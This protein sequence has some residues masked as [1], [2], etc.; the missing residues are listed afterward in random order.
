MQYKYLI[1]FFIFKNVSLF[2]L[3][4]YC[5]NFFDDQLDH[6]HVIHVSFFFFTLYVKLPLKVPPIHTAIIFDSSKCFGNHTINTKI[7]RNS[8]SSIRIDVLGYFI[9]FPGFYNLWYVY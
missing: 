9:A 3:I 1:N 4:Y 5:Y 2:L 7:H 6:F 8:V